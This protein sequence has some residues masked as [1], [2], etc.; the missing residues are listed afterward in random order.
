MVMFQLLYL[1]STRRSY[2]KNGP[3]IDSPNSGYH[4]PLKDLH[5]LHPP[6]AGLGGLR[7]PRSPRFKATG[8]EQGPDLSLGPVIPCGDE[9]QQILVEDLSGRWWPRFWWTWWWT[10]GEHEYMK[11][12]MEE[13]GRSCDMW[14]S[15][16]CWKMEDCSLNMFQ[17]CWSL[18][19]DRHAGDSW[20]NWVKLFNNLPAAPLHFDGDVPRRAC[21]R[22]PALPL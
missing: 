19:L 2:L 4:T 3:K 15:T 13:Y 22:R 11:F 21:L 17:P 1:Q 20:W 18:I 6:L 7:S 5:P 9:E 14:T 8:P 16:W 12:W 10:D